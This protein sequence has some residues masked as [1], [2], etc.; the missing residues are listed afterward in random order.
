MRGAV[1]LYIHR[2]LNRNPLYDLAVGTGIEIGPGPNPQIIDSAQTSV[3]YLERLSQGEWSEGD[4]K[5]KYG[6]KHADWSKYI[7]GNASSVPVDDNSLDFVFSSHV[8]EHLANPLGHLKHWKDKLR[9]GGRI[10]A[11]VPDMAGCKDYQAVPTDVSELV[12]EMRRGIWEPTRTHYENFFKYRNSPPSL[13]DEYLKEMKS[14]HV[15][16]Y[17]QTNIAVLLDYA[18]RELA[19]ASYDLIFERNHKDFYFVLYK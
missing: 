9:A 1:T 6:A 8:F 10:I 4:T 3:K 14:I 17:T 5:G 15:H 19:F 16:F 7:I 13:V 18:V 11:V 12:D 2:M